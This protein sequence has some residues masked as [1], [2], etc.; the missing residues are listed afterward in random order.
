MGTTWSYLENKGIVTDT[1]YPYASGRGR[2]FE[3]QTKCDNGEP[4][5]KYT[6]KTTTVEATKVPEIKSDI[7]N[8]GPVETGFTVYEDFMSYKSGIY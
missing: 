5:L 6:C 3:C 4:W 8:N 7:F 1:C 2:E